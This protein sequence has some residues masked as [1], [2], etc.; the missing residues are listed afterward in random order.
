MSIQQVETI[1][2]RIVTQGK[3]VV[4]T[5]GRHETGFKDLSLIHISEPTRP[6]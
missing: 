6:Y 4:D 5:Q 3:G 2:E 1:S